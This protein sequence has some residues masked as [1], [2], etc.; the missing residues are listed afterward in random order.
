LE[1]VVVGDVV[2]GIVT[3][4]QGYRLFVN[5]GAVRDGLLRLPPAVARTYRR[6]SAVSG[7]TITSVDL[8]LGHVN[9]EFGHDLEPGTGQPGRRARTPQPPRLSRQVSIESSLPPRSRHSAAT[10][11]RGDGSG[12]RGGG[13][14]GGSA[15][16]GMGSGGNNAGSWLRRPL[17]DDARPRSSA[18]ALTPWIHPQGVPL[19]QVK[20]GSVVSGTV[21]NCS[22]YG[23]FVNFGAIK[24][25][26][27]HL[28]RD[29]CRDVK[30]GDKIPECIVEW[31]DL[32]ANRVGLS[33]LDQHAIMDNLARAPLTDFC[34]GQIVDG[35]VEA[36]NPFGIFVNIGAVTTAKLKGV[37]KGAPSVELGKLVKGLRIEH[38]D[39]ERER[40]TLALVDEDDEGHN[41]MAPALQTI[42]DKQMS[43]ARRASAMGQKER[44]AM[45]AEFESEVGEVP[46]LRP[47]DFA[48]GVVSRV[49]V[50]G[51]VMDIGFETFTGLLNVPAALRGEFLPGD[52][53]EGMVVTSINKQAKQIKFVLDSP[54]LEVTEPITTKPQFAGASVAGAG[55]KSA[56]SGS[57][58]GSGTRRRSRPIQASE[59]QASRGG[60]CPLD[61]LWEGAV[62]DGIVVRLVSKGVLVDIGAEKLGILAVSEDVRSQLR[63]GDV[64]QGMTIDSID[65]QKRQFSLFMEDPQLKGPGE[66]DEDGLAEAL[67][68]N[69]P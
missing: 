55:P 54:A 68:N 61:R 16:G 23:V 25:G 58:S 51:V 9:L 45:R 53:V 15:G 6:G 40:I 57:G 7:L 5:F 4:I 17:S 41:S 36:R 19:D 64:I 65:L 39:Y 49:T 28:P 2:D 44:T 26:R 37:R 14:S 29:V 47:G 38:I 27:L 62:A 33:V 43:T 21:T 42:P 12:G 30:A 60:K 22:R 69:V 11:G 32:D 66:A 24:D 13:G 46:S 63:K 34:E 50:H 59:R 48:D 10:F 56:P 8:A 35:V 1:E 31:V 3:H 67:D 20:V 52:R 18:P